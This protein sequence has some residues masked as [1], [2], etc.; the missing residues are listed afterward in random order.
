MKDEGFLC[1]KPFG[2]LTFFGALIL[3]GELLYVL[4]VVCHGNVCLLSRPTRQV[5][6]PQ[7]VTS[8]LH[9]LFYSISYG[10]T[11]FLLLQPL[12]VKCQT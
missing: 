12:R 11:Q 8:P 6:R 7:E 2:N 3:N 1:L 5:Q 4:V 10:G 9:Q